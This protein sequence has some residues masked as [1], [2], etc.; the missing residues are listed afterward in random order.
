MSSIRI[1]QSHKDARGKARN[2]MFKMEEDR[3]DEG[4]V[5]KFQK[6]EEEGDRPLPSSSPCF[7]ASVAI[8]VLKASRAKRQR[9]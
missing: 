2:M 5:Q 9:E 1:A 6:D 8:P 3:Q 4:I 7:C